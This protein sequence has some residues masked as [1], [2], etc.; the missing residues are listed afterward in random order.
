MYMNPLV[1]YW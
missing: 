1:C